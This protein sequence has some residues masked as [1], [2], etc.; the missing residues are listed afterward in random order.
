[1]KTFQLIRDTPG[2][3]EATAVTGIVAEATV[4]SGGLAVLHWLTSPDGTEVYPAPSGEEAM[5][6][7]R[8]SSG[9]SRFAE[10]TAQRKLLAEYVDV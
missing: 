9:R 1:M 5:R 7:V 3:T 6:E 4:F 10:T 8:E 2:N